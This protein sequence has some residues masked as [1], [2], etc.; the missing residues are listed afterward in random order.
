MKPNPL[1]HLAHDHSDEPDRRSLSERLEE[2]FALHVFAVM[3]LQRRA[4]DEDEWLALLSA[5]EP[6]DITAAWKA[7]G[8]VPA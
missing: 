5:D 2:A 7:R 1:A 8:E 3:E 6:I 4:K